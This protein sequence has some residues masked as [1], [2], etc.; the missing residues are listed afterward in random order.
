MSLRIRIP[1]LSFGLFVAV[2]QASAQTP[3]EL[4]R[5]VPLL[6]DVAEAAQCEGGDTLM[7]EIEGAAAAALM[8]AQQAMTQLAPMA[9]VSDEQSLAIETLLDHNLQSCATDAEIAVRRLVDVTQEAVNS[10]TSHL[11]D[12]RAAALDECGS[13]QSSGYDACYSRT[14]IEYQALTRDEANH[15]LDALEHAYTGW[16]NKTASCLH[17]RENAVATF[18][19]AQ[20]GGPFAAQAVNMRVLSWSLVYLHAETSGTLCRTIH[21]AAHA[22]DAAL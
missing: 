10:A 22:L 2:S 17:Q 4:W 5:R 14:M 21:E 7:T 18:E 9:A 11:L 1:A 19:R 3:E 13:E 16:R 6:P 12:R 15:R 8:S 20:V